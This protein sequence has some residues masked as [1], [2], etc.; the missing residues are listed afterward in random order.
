MMYSE[1]SDSEHVRIIYYDKEYKRDQLEG[2]LK[3]YKKKF[4]SALFPNLSNENIL[5]YYFEL[6]SPEHL[7]QTFFISNVNLNKEKSTPYIFLRPKIDGPRLETA[8]PH[9]LCVAF[10]GTLFEERTGGFSMTVFALV[11]I[12]QS[13]RKEFELEAE[14]ELVQKKI[15]QFRKNNLL[16]PDYVEMLQN[17]PISITTQDNLDRWLSYLDW[18]EEMVRVSAQGIRYVDHHVNKKGISFKAVC[19]DR[20]TLKSVMPALRYDD[21]YAYE[22]EYSSDEWDFS[23]NLE[24]AEG[25]NQRYRPRPFSLGSYLEHSEI[26]LSELSTADFPNRW[27]EPIAINVTFDFNDDDLEVIN[28]ISNN[29]NADL[30][31]FYSDIKERIHTDGFLAPSAIG[32]IALIDRLKR[33]LNNFT[34]QGGYS[35]NL[36]TYLFDINK[37]Q[38]PAKEFVIDSWHA[39]SLNEEQKRAV[40]VMCSVPDIALIQGPPGT[41]KTTVIAEAIYQLIKKGEKV[42]LSSQSNTAV[43]NA[44]EKL[45]QIPGIRAVRFGKEDR[46]DKEL[47]YIPTNVLGFFYK[48]L[49]KP[50]QEKLAAWRAEESRVIALKKWS[51][52]AD[53]ILLEYKLEIHHN[54]KLKSDYEE[55][56][57]V[58]EKLEARKL[59]FERNEDEKKAILK[60]VD[61]I[62]GRCLFEKI[63]HFPDVVIDDFH[64]KIVIPL[65]SVFSQCGIDPF[66]G[67]T[68]RSTASRDELLFIAKTGLDRINKVSDFKLLLD[69]EYKRINAIPDKEQIT[70]S[71]ASAKVVYLDSKL[72]ELDNQMDDLD[73]NES[74]YADLERERRALR[75]EVKQIKESAIGADI[76]KFKE[77]FNSTLEK[78]QRSLDVLEAMYNAKPSLLSMLTGSPRKAGLALLQKA[79]DD[80]ST[81]LLDYPSVMEQHQNYCLQKVE[82]GSIE[83]NIEDLISK[84]GE[85]TK[86]EKLVEESN[87]KTKVIESSMTS[88]IESYE[89]EFGMI[90]PK[91]QRIPDEF[92]AFVS[93]ASKLMNDLS[94]KL[95][96]QLEFRNSTT[97]ILEKWLKVL[98]KPNAEDKSTVEPLYLKNCQVVGMTCT[99]NPKIL[100]ENEYHYFDTVIIDEVSKATP[101]ELIMPLMLGRR[102]VLVGDHRQLPPLFREKELAWE[103]VIQM[104][105]EDIDDEQDASDGDSKQN[106]VLNQANYDKY[107]I[108]VT[109]SLFKQYFESADSRIKSSL[110]TQYRMHPQIMDTINNFYENRLKCGIKDPEQ[111]RNHGLLIKNNQCEYLNHNKHVV[112]ID[113]SQDPCGKKYYETKMQQ[114]GCYNDLEARILISVLIDINNSLNESNQTKSIGIIS[115]YAMQIR[116]LNI[117]LKQHIAKFGRLSHVKWRISTVDKFQG[118][119]Q[120]IILVSLVRNRPSVRKSATAFVAQFERVNVAMSRARELLIVTGAKDMLADYPV[121][122]PNMDKEGFTESYAYKNVMEQV[123]IRG[124]FYPSSFIISSDEWKAMTNNNKAGKTV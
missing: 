121:L 9:G 122:I 37:A 56:R 106:L 102:A 93:R 88:T 73:E 10:K 41:G 18:R 39:K 19:Q 46:M 85:S 63:N 31:S 111:E 80:V 35:P 34:M 25:S 114:K 89:S 58:K 99:E 101:P 27:A 26:N 51:E 65:R 13:N 76:S 36:S 97:P 98:S 28:N 53:R 49:S 109:A 20:E 42:L 17:N 61:Y 11:V 24:K 45:A 94:G 62:S 67:W 43:D 69:T 113:S 2:T 38:L 59:E 7:S 92:E 5:D 22:K 32:D 77:Y 30:K 64:S 52:D 86:L 60:W 14:A 120:D 123:N 117:L 95:D 84:R 104:Q 90:M 16:T 12:S 119:E 118:R 83:F 55:N 8:F 107:K 21:I 1:N 66:L 105:R 74:K 47:D 68:G 124:A 79:I 40:S 54:T 91:T 70:D 57:Q 50:S 44:L 33:N 103:E 108:M 116:Q 100:A 112:W 78:G 110:F 96:A 115:F 15:P 6:V 3:G 72:A 81:F 23:I 75:K 71:E 29:P 48:V 87:S 82:N 4:G